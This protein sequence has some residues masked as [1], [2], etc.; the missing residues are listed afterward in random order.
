MAERTDYYQVLG[1]GKNASDSEIKLAYKR[2]ARQYHPDVY[3]GADAN[4]KFKQIN[5]A[6]EVLSDP[7][8]RQL[9]DQYGHAAFARGAGPAGADVGPF[10]QSY[11]YYGPTGGVNVDFDF[12]GFSD[13]F[14]IFE[15]FF[16]SASPFGQAFRRTPT[17][18]MRV[19]F[20][21]AVRGVEKEVEVGGKRTKI[22]IPA[23]VD[24]GT[25]IRFD[26]FSVVTEV[27]PH[28][29]FERRG[30]SI[31]TELPI[32]FAQ[33]AL[34][35]TVPIRTLDGEVKVKIPPGIQSGTAIRLRGRGVP[36]L[37][38]GGRGDHYVTV[39]VATPTRISN[40]ER[41]LLEQLR[42]LQKPGK[43]GWFA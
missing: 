35:D 32:T 36:Y 3:K 30:Y 8:K 12:G 29:E 26:N 6:Y 22:K 37:R 16:G 34:G 33:A 9:Y 31:H 20:E 21:D 4:E 38:S 40:K 24:D 25:R 27:E 42:D 11:T 2:L 5:Q 43:K 28:R 23:G 39:R 41:A 7:K 10:G 17:Y 15:Q 13:P 1:I 18:R 14:E 19:S